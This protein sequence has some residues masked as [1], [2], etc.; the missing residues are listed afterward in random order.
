MTDF[1][2]IYND[3]FKIDVNNYSEI[4]RFYESNSLFLD[5]KSTFLNSDD[6]NDYVLIVAQFV[7]SLE[8]L[9]KYSKANKYSNKLLA[10][11]DNNVN[12][13]GIKLKDFTPYWRFL[14][15]KGELFTI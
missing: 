1:Q 4:I 8:N 10:F 3:F 6:F 15:A 11:I 13:Y 5:N 14:Q 2:N 12:K 7:I 9:G